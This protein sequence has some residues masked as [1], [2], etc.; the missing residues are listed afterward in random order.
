MPCSEMCQTLTFTQLQS[1]ELQLEAVNCNP[2]RYPTPD[3]AKLMGWDKS[4][5][6]EQQRKNEQTV[7]TT[8]MNV[9]SDGYAVS[10]CGSCEAASCLLQ[11]SN[12]ILDRSPH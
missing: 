11:S 8:I 5:L 2:L 7:M 1:T 9:Q 4:N 12:W 3:E 6:M 10:P